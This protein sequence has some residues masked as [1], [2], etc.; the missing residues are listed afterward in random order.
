MADHPATAPN[1]N[2]RDITT[3]LDEKTASAT[4][5]VD[6]SPADVFDFIRR[7]ANHAEISGDGSVRGS[8]SGADVL[9]PES[10]FRMTMRRGVP[11][12]MS[13]KV[14]EFDENRVIAWCH[15]GGHRWRWELEPTDDGKTKVT[16]TFDGTTSRAPIVLKLMGLPKGHVPNVEKSIANVQRHFAS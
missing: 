10:R 1:Q 3:T 11:Y 6:A 8:R 7:P 14:V 13:S 16:E 15:F 4:G 2:A 12:R 9:G 5:I